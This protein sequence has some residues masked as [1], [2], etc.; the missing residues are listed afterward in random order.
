MPR[1]PARLEGELREAASHH[2]KRRPARAAPLLSMEQMPP[3]RRHVC[4]CVCVCVCVRARARV[5]PSPHL[6]TSWPCRHGPD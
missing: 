3:G 6:P 1:V 2:L 4:V 5:S